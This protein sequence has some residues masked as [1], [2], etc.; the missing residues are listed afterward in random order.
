[1]IRD[2]GRLRLRTTPVH[3][4]RPGKPPRHP[5]ANDPPPAPNPKRESRHH[6]TRIS[7]QRPAQRDVPVTMSRTALTDTPPS[8]THTSPPGIRL[9]LTPSQ[10]DVSVTAP[11]ENSRQHPVQRDVSATIRPPSPAILARARRSR[12]QPALASRRRTV[13]REKLI[14]N[15]T[16]TSHWRRPSETCP[17]PAHTSLSPEPE[18]Q[19]FPDTIQQKGPGRRSHG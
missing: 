19:A 13:Q 14:T 3:S 17:S 5:S 7:R 1:M 2:Y 9:S 16:H 10:R 8:E 12:H 11:H 18:H 15:P 4:S 6:L